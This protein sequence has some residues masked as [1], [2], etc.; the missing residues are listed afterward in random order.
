MAIHALTK[1]NP[2]MDL[3]LKLL[4]LPAFAG[5]KRRMPNFYL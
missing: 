3:C 2:F 1:A 5:L 4:F